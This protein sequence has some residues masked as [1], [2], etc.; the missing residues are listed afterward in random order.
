M[1][2]TIIWSKDR[3]MQCE[4]LLRSAAI[5]F[6]AI[7]KTT[8]LVKASNKDFN[9]GYEILESMK[10]PGVEFVDE[11]NFK[12]DIVSILLASRADYIL[13]NSDDN[14]FINNID[15]DKIKIDDDTLAFSLRL[16]RQVGFCEPSQMPLVLPIFVEDGDVLKWN[17][18][19]C[20]RR[21]CWGL[22]RPCDSSVYRKKDLVKILQSITFKNPGTMEDGLNSYSGDKRPFMKSFRQS[23][24]VNICNNR[25]QETS[26]CRHGEISAMELNEK[27]LKGLVIDTKNIYHTDYTQCHV[28]LPYEYV[29]NT[30]IR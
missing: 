22:P 16:G 14:V 28:E 18:E 21:G 8:V 23:K 7:N 30:T 13:G 26:Q 24:I 3:A 17:W 1:I 10:Y 9:K 12:K 29:K 20:D 6:P 15:L 27:F 4:L 19:L 11:T 2:H 5:M 25:V